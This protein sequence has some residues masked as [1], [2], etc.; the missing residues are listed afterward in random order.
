MKVL[1]FLT[2][3]FAFPVMV[4]VA[5]AVAVRRLQKRRL[6]DQLL[7]R[8]C[9]VRDAIA[10][11]AIRG[12]IS[13][14]SE[15]FEFFYTANARVIHRHKKMGICFNDFARRLIE[16]SDRKGDHQRPIDAKTKRLVRQVRRADLETKAI[17]VSWIEACAVMLN[18]AQR[19]MWLERSLWKMRR[20]GTNFY[21]WVGKQFYVP[22]PQRAAANLISI[23]S[24]AT[25]R[26]NTDPGFAREFAAS[27]FSSSS[28]S[29][30]LQT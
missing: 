17:V 10:M 4:S 27:W 26:K 30:R 5:A 6:H 24:A 19:G 8:F 20:R 14:N 22:A 11:K 7:Y 28:I 25:G 12:E 9:S 21:R 13:E 23:L 1:I 3:W 2:I 15:I 18:E 29:S 16:H